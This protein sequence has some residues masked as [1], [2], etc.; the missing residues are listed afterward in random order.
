MKK[1]LVT[2]ITVLCLLCGFFVPITVHAESATYFVMNANECYPN[3]SKASGNYYSQHV[4][5][6]CRSVIL[7]NTKYIVC[8]QRFNLG[9]ISGTSPN[10]CDPDAFPVNSTTSYNGKTYWV[11]YLNYVDTSKNPYNIPVFNETPSFNRAV[12]YTY[13]EGAVDPPPPAPDYGNLTDVRFN[14]DIAGSGSAAVNNIDHIKWN[15]END[16][17]G[18]TFDGTERVQIKAIAG[19]YTSNSRNG[20]LG[21]GATDFDY[22]SGEEHMLAEYPV[23]RG[24]YD[25]SWSHVITQLNAGSISDFLNIRLK[26]DDIWLKSGWIYQIRLVAG[27]YNSEWQTIYNATSSGVQNS[28]T[29]E[30]S[31]E[32][33]VELVNVIQSIN[34]MNS[35]QNENWTINNITINMDNSDGQQTTQKPWWAYLLEAIVKAFGDILSFLGNLIGDLMDAI[36]NLFK[37]AEFTINEYNDFKIEIKQNSGLFGQAFDFI[38]DLKSTFTGVQY[39]EPILHWQGITFDGIVFLPAADYNLNEYV[40]MWGL[41]NFRQIAFI[42]SDG[43]IFF[44]LLLL[45]IRK[46]NEVLKK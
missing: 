29:V 20:I 45:I 15:P 21:L 39:Q 22:N 14:T 28:L 1:R 8:N 34:T 4:N 10:S 40:E 3:I 6:E 33:N 43:F 26:G 30:N 12:Y 17:N 18:I 31:T 16:S 38:T 36:T 35:S 2:T 19:N 25:V 24:Y 13:G 7:G 27:D 5:V 23:T 37:P 42:C 41:G 46:L 44:S 11:S 9:S 32:L